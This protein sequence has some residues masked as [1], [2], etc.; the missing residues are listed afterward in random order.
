MRKNYLEK[1]WKK[2][3]ELGVIYEIKDGKVVERKLGDS[4]GDKVS[5]KIWQEK[6]LDG[7]CWRFCV[8]HSGKLLE[9][10]TDFIGI[11]ENGKLINGGLKGGFYL[12]GY[13][14]YLG[15]FYIYK[16][17]AEKAVKSIKPKELIIEKVNRIKEYAND[18]LCSEDI[19]F[20][21]NITEEIMEL[22][23]SID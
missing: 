13:R 15:E 10:Y 12:G 17:S 4:D 3:N 8:F 22:I 5:K 1:L 19:E 6:K 2:V 11:D 21:D 9:R 20:F 23:K 18:C 16:E 14:P 7:G